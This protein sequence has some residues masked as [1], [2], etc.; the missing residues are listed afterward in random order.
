ML[1]NWSERARYFKSQDGEMALARIFAWNRAKC[2]AYCQAVEF[3][4]KP[5]A[6]SIV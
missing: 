2:G 4:L 3:G 1:S 5:V 6:A